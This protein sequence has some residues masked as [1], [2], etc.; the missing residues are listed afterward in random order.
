MVRARGSFCCWYLRVR[1]NGQWRRLDLAFPSE[2]E[3]REAADSVHR[4]FPDVD[5]E[6]E[7]DAARH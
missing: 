4:Q 7:P 6:V 3:A 1:L 2:E 5:F